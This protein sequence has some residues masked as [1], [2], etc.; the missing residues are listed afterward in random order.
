[1]NK[2]ELLIAGTGKTTYLIEEALKI[3]NKRVLITTYTINCRNEIESKIINKIGYIPNNI[4]IQTWFSFLLEHG[5]RPYK[6]NIRNKR[7]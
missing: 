5:I 3:K 7:S 2:N 1:M 4:V 6:K